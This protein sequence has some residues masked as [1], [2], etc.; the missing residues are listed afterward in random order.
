MKKIMFVVAVCSLLFVACDP[1]INERAARYNP[2]EC[3][4]CNVGGKCRTCAGSGECRFCNGTGTRITS[5]ESFTGQ[6]VNLVS[7]EEKCPFC[8]ATG[9]CSHCDGRKICFACDGTHKVDTNWTF[10]IRLE[11]N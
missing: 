8:K 11:H 7:Y 1:K 3:P 9:V 6:G 5:T 4:I 2:E 10:L